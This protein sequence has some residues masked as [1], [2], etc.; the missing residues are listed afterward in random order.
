MKEHLVRTSIGSAFL[1]IFIGY[2]IGFSIGYTSKRI[3]DRMDNIKPIDTSY[4]KIVLDSIQ[5]NI[6]YRDTTI[7]NI[8]RKMK[9]E[10]EEVITASDSDA[11]MQFKELCS[12]E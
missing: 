4:N 1:G 5:Y 11:V 10:I 2:I 9:Y 7:Y 8:K 6:D 12:M 3:E